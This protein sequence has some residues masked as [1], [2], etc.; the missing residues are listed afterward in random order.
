MVSAWYILHGLIAAPAH[1]PLHVFPLEPKY[2]L[3]LI[4]QY[5]LLPLTLTHLGRALLKI[6]PRYQLIVE[7]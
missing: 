1:S 7:L 6:L 5:L 4:P 2:L 3:I